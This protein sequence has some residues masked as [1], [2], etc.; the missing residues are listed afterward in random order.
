MSGFVGPGTAT[1][2]PN[3]RQLST[4]PTP[5]SWVSYEPPDRHFSILAPSDGVEIA[6]PISD[7]NGDATNFH[8][9]MGSRGPVFCSL[10]WAEGPNSKYTDASTLESYIKA[11]NREI[12]KKGGTL[13]IVS[14]EVGALRVGDY[15]GKEYSLHIGEI[16]GVV[17]ILS[18][19]MGNKRELLVLTVMNKTA[20]EASANQFLNS[21]KVNTKSQT[22]Q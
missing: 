7:E 1:G 2:Q 22:G 21:L 10:M 8:Y 11:L 13:S 16:S 12:A 18:K 15:V 5:G 6:R 20:D 3:V 17:R 9:V 4:N 14:K 19:Q